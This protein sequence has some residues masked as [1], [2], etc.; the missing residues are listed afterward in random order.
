MTNVFLYGSSGTGKT[1]LGAE[2]VKIKLSQMNSEGRP[3]RVIVSQY[4][5][6]SESFLLLENFRD[7]HFS[8][9]KFSI[10]CSGGRE[11]S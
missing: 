9:I 6:N 1:I 4:D 7:K 11:K 8:P 3:V 2:I 10:S 5:A